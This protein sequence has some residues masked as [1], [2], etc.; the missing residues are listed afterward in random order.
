MTVNATLYVCTTCRAGLEIPEDGERPGEAMLNALND[1]GAPDG[2]DIKG[3]KC[4]SACSNGAAIALAQ[5]GKWTYVYGNLNKEEH[6][7]DI[8]DGAAAYAATD[9]GIIPWRQRSATFKK[10]T[11]SRI[12]A[13]GS[14]HD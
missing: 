4:L 3:V 5:D 8:I 9:D 12:P 1:I 10:H 14:N 6:L 7:Q 2:V 11:L 13:L